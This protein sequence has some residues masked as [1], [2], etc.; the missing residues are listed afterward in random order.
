MFWCTKRVKFHFRWGIKPGDQKQETGN[1]CDVVS[2]SGIFLFSY[3]QRTIVP[4]LS[5][6]IG[7]PC[8]ND[9]E[10]CF[11]QSLKSWNDVTILPSVLFLLSRFCTSLT[12]SV[13]QNTRKE[14]RYRK[15]FFAKHVSTLRRFNRVSKKYLLY[16]LWTIWTRAHK[17][18]KPSLSQAPRGYH[19][20]FTT[21][22]D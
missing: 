14:N 5:E 3:K 22:P 7:S 2:F 13:H 1:D 15:F 20:G 4:F 19:C 11:S 18:A 10:I 9:W 6:L 21:L 8:E 12:P 17:A 16:T